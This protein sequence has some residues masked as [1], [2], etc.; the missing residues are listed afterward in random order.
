[1]ADNSQISIDLASE[2]D[3]AYGESAKS[4]TT[5]LR[6]SILN[7]HY[8]NG[9]RYHAYHSGAYCDFADRHPSARVI[10]T[11]LSPIQPHLVPPN[12]QFEVDDCCD[13]WTYSVN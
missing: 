8:E 2:A 11:D 5:S 6:S 13:E 1:M 7:Y 3:S 12:V 9:R 4:E 10:G